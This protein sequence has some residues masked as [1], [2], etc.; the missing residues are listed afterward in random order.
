MGGV[1]ESVRGC[2][3]NRGKGAAEEGTAFLKEILWW[4]LELVL[5]SDC[6]YVR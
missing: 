4:V 5:R 3:Y 6:R 1:R 2:V